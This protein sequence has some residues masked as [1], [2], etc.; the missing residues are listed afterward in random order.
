[1]KKTSSS[2]IFFIISNLLILLVM[3]KLISIGLWWYLPDSGVELVIKEKFQPKYQKVDFKNILET[4]AAGKDIKTGV[5]IT[6]IILKGLYGVST[7]GF[8]VVSLNKNPRKTTIV[9]V[10][11]SYEGY[12]LKLINAESVVFEKNGSDFILNFINK[13]KKLVDPKSI[14][15]FDRQNREKVKSFR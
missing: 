11:E 4:D 5:S 7:N 1:M 8:I 13:E 12:K 10:G 3:A 2:G 6:N 9:E 15:A 14:N